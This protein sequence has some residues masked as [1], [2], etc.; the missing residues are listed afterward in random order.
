MYIPGPQSSSHV[1]TFGP[2]YALLLG[3]VGFGPTI[4]YRDLFPFKP[5]ATAKPAFVD[6]LSKSPKYDWN[7]V[8][9]AIL[10]IVFG[11]KYLHL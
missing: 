9:K 5:L 3:P 10:G 2:V 6:N 8:A 1:L 11:T 7:R 4:R